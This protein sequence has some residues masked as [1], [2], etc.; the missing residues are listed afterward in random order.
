MSV[1]ENERVKVTQILGIKVIFIWGKQK[2]QI[3]KEVL[4]NEN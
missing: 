4:R 2:I 1:L 3:W